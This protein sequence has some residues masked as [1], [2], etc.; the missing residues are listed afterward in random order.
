MITETQNAFKRDGSYDNQFDEFGNLIIV[1]S[2]EK[3]FAVTLTQD[4]YELNSIT[5]VY[6]INV[7]EFKDRLKSY[8]S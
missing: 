5:N 4:V 8:N 3:Y 6:D 2:T 7:S 1:D